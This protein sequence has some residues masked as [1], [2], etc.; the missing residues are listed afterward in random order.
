MIGEWNE[1][2]VLRLKDLWTK[3]LSC[4]QIANEFACG[5]TRSAIIGKVH[6]LKLPPRRE[7]GQP[8]PE[9]ITK[10]SRAFLAPPP[11]P[12]LRN[13]HDPAQ[14]RNPS[15]NIEASIVAAGVSPGL[16]ERLQEPSDGKGIRL[17]DLTNVT[18]R[19]P[20][21]HPLDENF[22][23]CGDASADLEGRR[24]YCPFHTL[25]SIDR[26][27]RSPRAFEKSALY[28]AN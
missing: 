25:K 13:G 27:I 24:P 21:G 1:A 12:R 23:F 8:R 7:A 6:R 10:E 2:Q 20:K 14:R 17:V 3:G 28:A 19:W 4:S 9:K 11:A 15:H 5:F 22:L 18:C 16:P 26:P